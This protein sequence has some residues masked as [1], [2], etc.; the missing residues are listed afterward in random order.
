MA[1]AQ[2]LEENGYLRDP[3]RSFN[4]KMTFSPGDEAP[5]MSAR[6][7]SDAKIESLRVI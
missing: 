6:E 4:A 3:G 2:G 5:R 1:G 7:Q